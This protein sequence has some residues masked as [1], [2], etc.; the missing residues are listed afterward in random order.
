M[1]FLIV[2]VALV[3]TASAFETCGKKGAGSRIVNGVAAV[4]GEF[5]WQVSLRYR[6]RHSCGGLRRFSLMCLRC[7]DSK[8]ITFYFQFIVKFII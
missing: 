1:N 3:A 8:T 6:H 5:P 7:I 4:H 2:L